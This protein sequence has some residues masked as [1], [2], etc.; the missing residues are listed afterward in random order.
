M[1]CVNKSWPPLCNV[2]RKRLTSF[3]SYIT[4]T[5]SCLLLNLSRGET[6]SWCEDT[7]VRSRDKE[8]ERKRKSREDL[9]KND[10]A[11]VFQ[12]TTEWDSHLEL[13]CPTTACHGHVCHLTPLWLEWFLKNRECG[14]AGA[15]TCKDQWIMW[16]KFSWT[17]RLACVNTDMLRTW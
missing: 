2:D 7:D 12:N 1:L 6:N 3:T 16:H 11:E 15:T 13:V 17:D 4:D 10:N 5:S 8:G 9:A 14:A